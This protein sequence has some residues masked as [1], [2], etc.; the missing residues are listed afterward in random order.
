MNNEL[1]E[2]VLAH[3]LG[4]SEKARSVGKKIVRATWPIPCSERV[5]VGL[6]LSF[7]G[8][9]QT[10]HDYRDL[11]RGLGGVMEYREDGKRTFWFV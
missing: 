6:G 9:G 3:T 11:A 10:F 4:A 8:S 1:N 2:L 5:R 7:A